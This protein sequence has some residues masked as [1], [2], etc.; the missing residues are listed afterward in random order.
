[1]RADLRAATLASRTFAKALKFMPRYDGR[2]P[3]ARR[4]RGREP[5]HGVSR[6]AGQA[7]FCDFERDALLSSPVEKTASK[8]VNR[9]WDVEPAKQMLI[10]IVLTRDHFPGFERGSAPY[11]DRRCA[12]RPL[13]IEAA[14]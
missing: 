8:A 4:R 1:M 10:A 6:R 12:S 2:L 5:P 9:D 13:N 11:R 14:K 3:H 7:P